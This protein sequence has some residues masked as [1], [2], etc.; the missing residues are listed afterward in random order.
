MAEDAIVPL[1]R[2]LVRGIEE[3]AATWNDPIPEDWQS[4]W[5]AV[6]LTPQGT[7]SDSHGYAYGPD[8]TWVMAIATKSRFIREPLRTFVAE[9]YPDGA[10]PAVKLLFQLELATGRY[11]VDY[12]DTD[13]SRWTPEP[14]NY[15]D[16][17][18]QL[19]PT[20]DD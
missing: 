9:R 12:E 10:K 7:Y 15:R 6:E 20:F 19:K 17:Q 13:V 8:G 11:N 18:A 1:M 4:F 3:G 5:L 16:L 2:A 14:E